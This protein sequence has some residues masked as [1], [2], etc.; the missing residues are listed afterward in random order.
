MKVLITRPRAQADVFAE[1]LR[2]VGI[3]PVLFPVIEIHPVE[4]NTA[5]ENAIVNIQKYDWVVFTSVNAVDVFLQ[6]VGGKH[7]SPLHKIAAVGPKTAEALR[8]R[9]I[10]PDF[11]PDEYVSE[12]IMAGFGDV[13]GKWILLPRAEIARKELP[14]AIVKAGGIPHEITVYQTLP[15]KVSKDEL[16]TL[17]SGVDVVTFTSA[18]TVENFVALTRQHGFDPLNLPNN[19]I[20]ACI[21]PVTEQA[22]KESGFQKIVIAKEYTTD[23]MVNAIINLETL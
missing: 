23:G 5:L 13:K 10:E 8:K 7:A 2:S 21:G 4:N 14:E 11:I 3:E 15:A 12:V 22:A 9:D 19:P 17:K 1:K 6:M 20:F 16:N 18:S